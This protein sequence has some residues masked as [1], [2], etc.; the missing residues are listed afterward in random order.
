MRDYGKVAP[1]FWLGATGKELRGNPEAQ[2]VALYLMTG[3]HSEWT[4]VFHC[5]ILYIAHETGMTME[6]ASKALARLIEVGFCLFDEASDTVFVKSMARFQIGPDLKESDKR[7]AG[8][9]NE[10]SKWPESRIKTAFLE[11]Y[12]IPFCLGFMKGDGS[13]FGAPSKPRAG[14][15]TRTGAGNTPQP[16]KGG[17]PP[18]GFKAWLE[19][20]KAENEKPIPAGDPVFAYCESVGIPHEYLTLHW[21]LFKRRYTETSKRY[22]DW[23]QVFRNSVRGNWMHV[24]AIRDGQDAMLT[25]VGEQA[26]REF[27]HREAA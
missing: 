19:A 13:P 15:R 2:I 6:G 12:N 17:I 23:R 14:A 9:R 27:D 22:R 7:V 1:Q 8:L 16:P 26:R 25:T 4:G 18:I 24:W 10:V 20:L 5:P 21:Q 11:L 3:P